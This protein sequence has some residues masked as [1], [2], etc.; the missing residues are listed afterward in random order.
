M[1]E[2]YAVDD[3]ERR[4][5]AMSFKI[6]PSHFEKLTRLAKKEDRSKSAIIEKCMVEY[7]KKMKI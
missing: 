3:D 5:H 7:F 4:T 6:K 2:R 1:R